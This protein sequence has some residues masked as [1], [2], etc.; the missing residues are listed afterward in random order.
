MTMA[1]RHTLQ[2]VLS[3]HSGLTTIMKKIRT[4]TLED[5]RRVNRDFITGQAHNAAGLSPA[6]QKILRD[7]KFTRD[8]INRAFAIARLS[9]T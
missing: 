1:E 3:R 8:E 9:T 5:V 4:L 6:S 2:C 7:S